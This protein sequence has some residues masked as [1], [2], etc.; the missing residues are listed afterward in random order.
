V[1]IYPTVLQITSGTTSDYGNRVVVAVIGI[2]ILAV[3]TML[4]WSAVSLRRRDRRP[5][6]DVQFDLQH[7]AR[8]L[9][10]GVGV[11]AL[12]GFM[13]VLPTNGATNI[14]PV[15]LRLTAGPLILAGVC[16][17]PR[18]SL[19]GSHRTRV[20][21]D[22][23]MIGTGAS[24]FAWYF[25]LGPAILT[26]WGNLHDAIIAIGYPGLDVLMVSVLLIISAKSRRIKP[27]LWAPLA[28]ASGLLLVSDCLRE[29]TLQS[30]SSDTDVF[31]S[32]RLAA[33]GLF[34]IGCVLLARSEGVVDLVDTPEED[35]RLPRPAIEPN[36]ESG[37]RIWNSLL[38]YALVPATAALAVYAWQREIDTGITAGV[39]LGTTILVGLTFF[40]QL[41]AGRENQSLYAQA[42]A[43][44]EQSQAYADSMEQLFD[45][46]RRAKEQLQENNGELARA[47]QRL[48]DQA[49]TDPLTGL[50][51]HRAMV[52]ALD[53]EL[54]RAARYGRPCSVIFLD[55]DH[56]KALND[57]C[58]HLC[59]DAVLRDI[60]HPIQRGLRAQDVAG[61]WGGEEFI[62][63]LPETDIDHAIAVAERVREQVSRHRFAAVGG[64]RLTCSIGVA[65]YPS[66]AGR[67]DDLI[68][69]A[70]KAMY[71]A[72]RLGKNQ[73]RSAADPTTMAFQ[74]DI[75]GTN[76]REETTTWGIVEALTTLVRAHDAGED[77]GSVEIADL[78]MRVAAKMGLSATDI[79]TIGLAARLHDV[80]MVS[81]PHDSSGAYFTTSGTVDLR[82]SVHPVVGADIVSRIPSLAMLAPMVRGHHERWDGSGFPDRLVGERIP[83]GARIIAACDFYVSM[84]HPRG[85]AAGLPP[86]V[87]LRELATRKSV[88][89]DPAVVDALVKTV[90]LPTARIARAS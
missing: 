72:K 41:L 19:S 26:Q 52:A 61:R 4:A 56:F 65:S 47:N 51:N 25:L 13:T 86:Q 84:V 11:M 33:M 49:T 70:D 66:E 80:G 9:L 37:K 54:D 60:I 76:S 29:L 85:A 7:A 83:M 34:A 74:T 31:A 58:G 15:L 23:L 77:A 40:R 16:A 8:L 71:A 18:A 63:V 78:A 39:V 46:L 59:G 35:A 73:V 82:A 6:T 45:E 62:I 50:P 24:T 87:A 57:S 32:I 17:L 55:L 12:A 88:E 14:L 20:L 79:R 44:Y 69:S 5:G 68:E 21:L 43:A 1:H 89:F 28:A 36:S 3:A 42:V 81:T 53:R 48:H 64:T 30:T 10:A 75:G 2:A 27:R 22:G 38:P 67:R 90:D